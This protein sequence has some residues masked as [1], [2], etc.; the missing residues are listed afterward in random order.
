MAITSVNSSISTLQNVVKSAV[1]IGG[2]NEK[3]Y[4]S[5]F[6]DLA[7]QASPLSLEAKPANLNPLLTSAAQ[8]KA[9]RP[10]LKTFI[11]KTGAKMEDA[12][13]FLYGTVGSNTDTRDWN[14]ILGNAD[15]VTTV[16]QATRALYMDPDRNVNEADIPDPK[17]IVDQAGNFALYQVKDADKNVISNSVALLDG[18]GRMIRDGG[19]TEQSIKRNAWLF[20]YDTASIANLRA[21]AGKISEQFQALIDKIS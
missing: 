9:S 14:A 12:I 10:D 1:A 13:E 8:S 6:L 3:V 7:S 2:Q 15:P 4:F 5:D 19:T 11:E 21:S 20:G 18:K 16:R 17:N